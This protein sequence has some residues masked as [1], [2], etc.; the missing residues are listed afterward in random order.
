MGGAGW[1]IYIA[2][3]TEDRRGYLLEFIKKGKATPRKVTQ[4]HLLLLADEEKADKTIAEMLHIGGS[5]VERTRL[6]FVEGGI[7]LA[8]LSDQCLDRRIGNVEILT[9]EIAA[10]EQERNQKKASVNWRFSSTDARAKLKRLY[11][12]KS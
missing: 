7:E 1:R 3:L 2:E 10:W 4:A 5:T 11:P 6:R 9:Y 12:S 8:V